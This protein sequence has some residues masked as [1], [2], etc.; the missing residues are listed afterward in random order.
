MTDY[1]GRGILQLVDFLNQDAHDTLGILRIQ[2]A[3]RLISKE[4]GEI[5]QDGTRKSKPL[6]L[7]SAQFLSHAHFAYML[8]A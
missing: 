1:D 6:L 2:I 7:S 4:Y 5:R 8:Q 3:C